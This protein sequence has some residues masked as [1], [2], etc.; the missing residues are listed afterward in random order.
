MKRPQRFVVTGLTGQVAQSLAMLGVGREDVEVVLLGRPQFD[1]TRLESIAN[2]VR[3]AKPDIIVSAAAYTAVDRA[4]GEEAEA[5]ATNAL[6]PAELCRIAKHLNV[7]IIH[8]STDYVFNG[9]KTEPYVE[10]DAVAPLSAYG[11]SKLAGELL[12]KAIHDDHAIIRTAWV[13]SP[14][15]RNFLRTMLR[16]AEARD[17]I[18]VVDDQIGSP[19]CAIELAAAVMTIG[20]KLLE[21][22]DPDKRGLFHL[23]GSGETTWARFA[24]EIFAISSALGGPAA[25]VVRIPTS[26]Y[27]TAARRPLNTSLSCQRI[28]ECHGVRLPEWRA[29]VARTIRHLL[30]RK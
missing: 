13:Y 7:P 28:A 4:E 17:E 6:G 21:T 18:S 1:L 26:S 23:S 30:Q 15:G 24:E 29:S 16:A 9:S 19:T 8:L 25:K 10:T 14:F 12:V 2:S 22:T 5:Y 20:H 11:R 27:P 3:S